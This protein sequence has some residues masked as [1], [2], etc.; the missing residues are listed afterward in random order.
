MAGKNIMGKQ[1]TV[2]VTYV[3]RRDI[4]MVSHAAFVPA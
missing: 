2:K 1:T 3:L 4:V